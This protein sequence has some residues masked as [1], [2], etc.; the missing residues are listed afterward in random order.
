MHRVIDIDLNGHDRPFRIHEDA[1]E[2]LKQYLDNAGARLGDDPDRAEVVDDLERSIGERLVARQSGVDRV[3]TAADVTAVLDQVGK[4][5]PPGI[6][7]KEPRRQP[8]RRKLYRIKEGQDIAGVCTGLSA[9]SDISLDWVRTIF[10]LGALVTAGLLIVVYI[11]LAFVLPVIG[12]RD[13][14]Y[15]EMARAEGAARP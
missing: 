1:Y 5:E 11:V 3:L 12:T 4:V 14:W 15:A 8:A 2:A 9:Y 7:S 13:E 6:G 10:V